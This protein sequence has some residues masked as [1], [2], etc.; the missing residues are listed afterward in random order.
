MTPG[1]KALG[2]EISPDPGCC[3]AFRGNTGCRGRDSFDNLSPTTDAFLQNL[4]HPGLKGARGFIFSSTPST[5]G[6]AKTA[7]PGVEVN[8]GC[9]CRDSFNT[10][11]L[12]KASTPGAFLQNLQHPGPQSPR[13][14][15]L[16]ETR[17]YIF[18]SAPSTPGVAKP[19]APGIIEESQKQGCKRAG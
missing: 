9:R 2:V 7:T 8:T 18:S 4:Q 11:S 17:G 16:K 10:R 12:T 14:P 5:P 19:A 6:V 1:L 13:L 3:R 15:G